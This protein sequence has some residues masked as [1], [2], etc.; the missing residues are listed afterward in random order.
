[1]QATEAIAQA[2]D[3]AVRRALERIRVDE[4]RHAELA[5]R[6]VAWALRAAGQRVSIW[7]AP[8]I[9]RA[10][11]E[12]HRRESESGASSDERRLAAFGLLGEVRLRQLRREALAEIV[13]PF[14]R[15]L[16]A[17]ANAGSQVA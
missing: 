13:L 6:T 10:G 2:R 1:M 16:L 5:W 3:P 15:T 17:S 7:L 12:A 4:T 14:A 9:A 11:D 8:A